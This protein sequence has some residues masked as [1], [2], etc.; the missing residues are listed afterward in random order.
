MET[1]DDARAFARDL[2]APVH[3]SVLSKLARSSAE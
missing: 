3:A 2:I 1:L